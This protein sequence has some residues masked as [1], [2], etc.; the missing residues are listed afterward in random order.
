MIRVNLILLA[1]LVA[2]ALGTVASQHEARRLFAALEREQVTQRRLD[3]E[4]RQ[5]QLEQSTWAMHA[6]IEKVA[7]TQLKMQ[8]PVPAKVQV[9]ARGEPGAA[10]RSTDAGPAEKRPPATPA[11]AAK[12]VPRPAQG[13]AR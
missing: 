1:L 12:P 3:T 4:F 10:A 7:L 2:S 8:M 6:R 11:A 9:V 5:L 13:G